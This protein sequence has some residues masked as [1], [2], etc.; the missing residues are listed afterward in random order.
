MCF[1]DHRRESDKASQNIKFHQMG[2]VAAASSF[3]KKIRLTE[4]GELMGLFHNSCKISGI[5]YLKCE[6]FCREVITC[7]GKNDD[8]AKEAK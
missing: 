5:P 2:T 3:S 8:Q 6:C 1:I 4:G 7:I